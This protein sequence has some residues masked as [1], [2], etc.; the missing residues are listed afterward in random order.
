MDDKTL[1]RKLN[2][3]AKLAQ[4]LNEEAKRRYGDDGQLFY[5]SEGTFH[6]MAGDEDA[7]AATR[8]EYIRFSSA[9]FCAMGTGSW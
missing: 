3:L 5:E 6:I 2:Q 7:G 9:P 1:Q 8:Q 4:E